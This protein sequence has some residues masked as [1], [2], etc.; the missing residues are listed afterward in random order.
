[1]N[2]FNEMRS[3][4]PEDAARMIFNQLLS[5]SFLTQ[6]S[7]FYTVSSDYLSSNIEDDEKENFIGAI[8]CWL[9]RDTEDGDWFEKYL[10]RFRLFT[11]Y[12]KELDEINESP[13]YDQTIMELFCSLYTAPST[14]WIDIKVDDVTVG[15][16][17]IGYGENCHLD[18]K[19]Y[20]QEAFIMHGYRNRGLMTQA[21][22]DFMKDH[23]GSYVYYVLKKNLKA[24]KFWKTFFTKAGYHTYPL[25]DMGNEKLL[26]FGWKK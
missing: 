26:Q 10:I 2:N 6:L 8:T 18:A 12:Q 19:Y 23:Q 21:L 25:Y 17:V 15:F 1:M 22:L 11:W 4:R 9:K 13:V 7:S 14:I 3:F 16:L 5:P 24:K 20:I